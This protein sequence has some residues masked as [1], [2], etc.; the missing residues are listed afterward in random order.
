[1]LEG[2]PLTLFPRF[3]TKFL[4]SCVEQTHPVD[5]E[6]VDGQQSGLTLLWPNINKLLGEPSCPSIGGPINPELSEKTGFTGAVDPKIV[7]KPLSGLNGKFEGDNLQGS[8]LPVC[9]HTPS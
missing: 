2:Q 8:L 7:Y 6:K 5:V 1:M 3:F 4:W 9:K